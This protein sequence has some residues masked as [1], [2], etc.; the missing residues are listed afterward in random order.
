MCTRPAARS[1]RERRAGQCS[2]RSRSLRPA[3]HRLVGGQPCRALTSAARCRK[4]RSAYDPARI[5]PKAFVVPCAC[6][7]CQ[8]HQVAS[9][10]PA[11]RRDAMSTRCIAHDVQDCGRS[12][13]KTDHALRSGL[14]RSAWQS[15][16]TDSGA[17][18]VATTVR[19]ATGSG[20]AQLRGGEGSDLRKSPPV[21]ATPSCSRCCPTVPQQAWRSGRGSCRRPP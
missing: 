8:S 10:P 4:R 13:E 1:R 16:S 6:H 7:K 18:S 11:P 15:L 5:P 21:A 20:N 12:V 19:R 17:T 3:I 9:V 2:A 14:I